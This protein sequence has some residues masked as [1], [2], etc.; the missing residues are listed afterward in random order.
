MSVRGRTWPICRRPDRDVP[1]LACGYPLPCPHHTAIIEGLAVTM[2]PELPVATVPKLRQIAR[3]LATPPKPA[4]EW[5]AWRDRANGARAK[6][7]ATRRR[8]G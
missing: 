4:R 8:P 7:R 1:G 2:P 6:R 3:A 5:G